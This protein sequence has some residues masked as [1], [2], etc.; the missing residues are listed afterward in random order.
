MPFYEKHGLKQT[1][2]MLDKEIEL[3]GAA[4]AL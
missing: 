3:M 2:K 4:P 1:G